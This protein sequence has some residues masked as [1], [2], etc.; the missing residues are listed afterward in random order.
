MSGETITNSSIIKNKNYATIDKNTQIVIDKKPDLAT[1]LLERVRK[2]EEKI[3]KL[4]EAE[5]EIEE[6]RK[7]GV[8]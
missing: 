5:K 7:L 3:K 1:D 2:L 6:L 8:E 4:E